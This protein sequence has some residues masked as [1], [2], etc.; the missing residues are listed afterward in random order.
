MLMNA[1]Y[2]GV[3]GQTDALGA[4]AQAGS[5]ADIGKMNAQA[6]QN[7]SIFGGLGQLGG[8]ALTAGPGSLLGSWMGL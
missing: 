4:M 6:Q 8:M 3:G 1:N 2:G 5:A 7:S